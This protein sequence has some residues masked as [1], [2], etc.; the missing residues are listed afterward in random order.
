MMESK[1]VLLRCA[2]QLEC[3]LLC[4]SGFDSSN[5]TAG[6]WELVNKWREIARNEYKKS[7]N[8]NERLST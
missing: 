8:S 1:E 6:L 2:K 7:N 3:K 5:D 4:M